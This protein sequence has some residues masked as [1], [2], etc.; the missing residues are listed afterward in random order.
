MNTSFLPVFRLVLRIALV[1]CTFAV[2][3][4]SIAQKADPFATEQLSDTLARKAEAE[5]WLAKDKFEMFF[6]SETLLYQAYPKDGYSY[7]TGWRHQCAMDFSK[8]RALRIP[9][10]FR[11]D[12][13]GKLTLEFNMET[14]CPHFKYV[15]T[16]TKGQVFLRDKIGKWNL[17]TLGVE[18]KD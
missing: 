18:L 8:T 15:F 1:A 14:G 5:K 6:P 9:T 13:D 2:A 17:R 16:G 4:S 12:E 7:M 3:S 11:V 10:T